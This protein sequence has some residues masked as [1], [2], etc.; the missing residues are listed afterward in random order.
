MRQARQEHCPL[1]FTSLGLSEIL[2][3]SVAR[4]GY[5]QPT[6][7]QEQS[8]P[9][10]LA[11]SDLLARAHTGTGKTAAFGLPMI[12]RLLVRSQ[13]RAG[14]RAPRGLVLVP[15]RELAI[16]VHRALATYGAPMNLRA[17]AIYGGVGMRPQRDALRRGVDIIV[18]TPGRLIDHMEQRS[19]DLSGLEILTLDEADRM[20]DLGFLP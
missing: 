17:T 20:L 3:H 14:S 19:V 8:I 10:V 4:L 16:Q 9:I 1:S 18:A 12:D 2:C 5:Q 13:R 7:V 15:T 6:A 11:G